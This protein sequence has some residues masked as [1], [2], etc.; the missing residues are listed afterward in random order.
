MLSL[1]A[2][3]SLPPPLPN[4]RATTTPTSVSLL[5][6]AAE[7]R[8]APLTS[9]LHAAL[10]KTGGLQSPQPLTASNS[11]LHAY[12]RCG[13]LPDAL[14]LLDE[15]P[16]RDAATCASLVSAHCRLGAPLDAIRAYLDMLTQDADEDGGVRPNEFT[17]AALLQ[18]CGSPRTRHWGGWC[19]ET[20]WRVGFAVTHL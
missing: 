13:L 16:R 8:D 9:A 17:A 11:L 10:L 6:G 14:R 5:R 15:M 12:L 18:A 3:S 1:S 2:T 20:S 7:R 4:P 19:M